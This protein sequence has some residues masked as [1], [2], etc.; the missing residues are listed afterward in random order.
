MRPHS[1]YPFSL[2]IFSIILILITTTRT[3]EPA[4]KSFLISCG[5]STGGTDSN[6]RTWL[7]DS[8]YFTTPS[9][10]D[11]KNST[12]KQ[13]DPS[14]PSQIPYMSA[15]IF[16]S[17]SSTF[18]FPVSSNT[19]HYIRL[20]FYPSA[21]D[22]SLDPNN[23]YF[24][25]D[26]NGFTLLNNFSAYLTAKALTKA[27][28][29]KEY[30]LVAAESGKLSITFTPCSKRHG[31]YAFIN[32]IEV[33]AIPD[34]FT[35]PPPLVSTH[36]SIS[37]ANSSLQTMIR[38]NVGGQYIS[39]DRDSG[40]L[41]RTWYDDSTYLFAAALG[42][43]AV[44]DKN[45]T[46]QYYS[47]LPEYIAPK[48][49]YA[50]A[51]TMGPDN[52]VNLNYNLSWVFQVDANFTYIVR[53]H[54]CE[55]FFTRNNQ[56][57]FNIYVNNQTA[58][59]G[60]DVYEWTQSK[61]APIYQDFAT[62]VVDVPGVDDQELWVELHPAVKTKPQYYDAILNGLEIFKINDSNG[63]LAGKNPT[64]SKLLLDSEAK[65][66]NKKHNNL[67]AII[68][69][70]LVLLVAA[71]CLLVY[72]RKK[73]KGDRNETVLGNWL[74]IHDSPNTTTE[75]GHHKSGAGCSISTQGLLCENF[76]M[77]EIKLATNNFDESKVIGVG[78]FGKVYKGVIRGVKEV[79]VKRSNPS[80]NQGINE[81]QNEIY[82]LSKL[83]HRHLV[84]LI[85]FCQEDGEMI[86]I[87]DYMA[88][89]TLQQHLYKS[90]KPSLPWNQRLEICI[91]AARGLHYLHTGAKF[92]I[93]HRDVKTTN[94]LLDESWVAKVSDFGLSKTGP[95]MNQTHVSTMVKGSFGYFDP[96]YFRRQQLTEKSDVYSFGVVLFEVLCGRQ[97]LDPTL[98][99]EQVSLAD[100][101]LM[102]LEKGSLEDII[103]T[104]LQGKISI[105][106]LN[107]F[108]EIAEKC[109]SDNGLERPSMGD[110]LWTLELALQLQKNADAGK[111]E[112]KKKEKANDDSCILF[113]DSNYFHNKIAM[114]TGR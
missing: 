26:A 43:T 104:R 81:F 28:F 30:S 39:P 71:L 89:G 42:V 31:S 49:V 14:L 101:A 84:S 38:L 45:L 112:E 33:I 77:E 52:R 76:S 67:A 64:P 97:A 61:G 93:I 13:Q 62:F 34:L 48:D 15:R 90:N 51:R 108:A 94:I 66:G 44:A 103:D 4:A 80:S 27:Y 110:V 75:C 7:P 40:G 50:T 11:T 73:R 68:A 74:A 32:G 88:N 70:G 99:T 86:L 57:K 53:L 10:I 79:A 106:C 82:M 72:L 114:A 17:S 95:N 20:H 36:Q 18:R 58:L 102:N 21:Y 47:D 9:S 92:T 85:G 37:V 87:Y 35:Q 12:A 83:R 113:D 19:R 59:E 60:A 109:L 16:T 24:S 54:F 100:W 1:R 56:R 3:E 22:S 25:V 41:S 65:K 105:D 2:I 96:E 5:S 55:L 111:L 63:N 23:S 29:I 91:G 69:T 78:G 46:I 107:K 6:G 98:P 8:K